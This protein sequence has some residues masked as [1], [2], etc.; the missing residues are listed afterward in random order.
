MVIIFEEG[1]PC[2]LRFWFLW[3]ALNFP[4]MPF[5]MLKDWQRHMELLFICFRYSRVAPLED[6]PK[7]KVSTVEMRIDLEIGIQ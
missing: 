4:K 5:H 1:Y 3:T 7:E 2:I 6:M